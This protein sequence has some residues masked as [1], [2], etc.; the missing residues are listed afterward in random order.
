MLKKASPMSLRDAKLAVILARIPMATLLREKCS[1][2]HV[3]LVVVRQEFLSS[4]EKTVRFI[5]ATASPNRDN[6]CLK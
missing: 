3:H 4:R 1:L 2:L 5:A 6:F